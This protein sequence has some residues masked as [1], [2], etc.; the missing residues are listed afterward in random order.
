MQCLRDPRIDLELAGMFRYLFPSS[1]QLLQIT[2][3]GVYRF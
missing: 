1:S 3:G 2:L